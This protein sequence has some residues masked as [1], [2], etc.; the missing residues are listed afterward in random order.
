MEINCKIFTPDLLERPIHKDD[1]IFCLVVVKK[2]NTIYKFKDCR[3]K[4]T[5][6]HYNY[7]PFKADFS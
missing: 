3:V 4:V 1:Y 2:L 6:L 7:V 5:H